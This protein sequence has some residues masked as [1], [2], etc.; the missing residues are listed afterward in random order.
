[1]TSGRFET[2][3]TVEPWEENAVATVLSR[4][5]I[6]VITA[7]TDVTPTITPSKVRKVRSLFARRLIRA[8][9]NDSLRRRIVPRMPIPA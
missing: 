1:M 8:S 4:P 7:I 6:I 2:L 9:R 3:K 5:L